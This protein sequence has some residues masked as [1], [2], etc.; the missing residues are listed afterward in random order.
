MPYLRT[1]DA[2]QLEVAMRLDADAVLTY[3]SRLGEAARSSG[4]DVIAPGATNTA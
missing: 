2:L 3:D 1:L 4:L